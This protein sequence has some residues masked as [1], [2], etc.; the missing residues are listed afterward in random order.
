L[1]KATHVPIWPGTTHDSQG[2]VQEAAH[3]ATVASLAESPASAA[4]AALASIVMPPE[5]PA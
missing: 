5:S 2:I 3:I 4:S 1:G